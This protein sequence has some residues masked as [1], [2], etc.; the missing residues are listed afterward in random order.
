ME[1]DYHTHKYPPPVC[2]LS[3]IDPVHAPKSHF[4][5]IHLN[6]ILQSTPGSSKWS[7]FLTFP[8]QNHV[9]TFPLTHKYYMP[10][11]SH[12]PRFDFYNMIDFYNMLHKFD[13]YLGLD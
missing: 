9:Y 7:R 3:Y 6:I 8:R 11:P 10:C 4:L 2:I 12:F 5:K 13:E 1:P